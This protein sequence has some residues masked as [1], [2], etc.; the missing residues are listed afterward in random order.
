MSGST[1]KAR[2]TRTTSRASACCIW[3]GGE[4]LIDTAQDPRQ[5]PFYV[6]TAH[7]RL[8]ALGT[9]FDVRQGAGAQTRLAVYEGAVE[10]HTRAGATAIVRA[11][12]QVRYD[13]DGV[14]AA[15]PADL[16]REAWT[17]G[18]LIA[19]NVPLADVVDELRRHYRGYL[20][21]APEAAGLRVFGS[22]P[23]N[24]PDQALA[25]LESVMPI[26][27]RR[28]LPWWVSIEARKPSATGR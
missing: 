22:Y 7:G 6:D 15:A 26:R 12:S 13:A 21:L 11:G 4:I 2:S 8:R 10:V 5:R 18:V 16:A 20:N 17:R 28:P 19:Q 27:V 9:R 3:C 23:A 25:M 1:P 24:D 14:S